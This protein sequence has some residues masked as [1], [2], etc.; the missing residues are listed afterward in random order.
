MFNKDNQSQ[1][2]GNNSKN[3]QIGTINN[4]GLTY[5]DARQIALDVFKANFIELSKEASDLAYE[6]ATKLI[7]GYFQ[8]VSKNPKI[9]QDE[10]KKPDIQSAIYEAQ[11]E[12]AKSGGEELR[13]LLTSL[14]VQ[15]TEENNRNLRQIALTESI[16]VV[17]KLTNEH[18]NILTLIFVIGRMEPSV[19]NKVE[20][21]D[22]FIND[23]IVPFI[24]P[25]KNDYFIY[26]HLIFAGCCSS[27]LGGGHWKRLGEAISNRYGGLLSKGFTKEEFEKELFPINQYPSLIINNLRDN[28]LLQI[29]ALSEGV[30]ET[31]AKKLKIT[32]DELSKLKLF[33]QKDIRDFKEIED[34][35]I[36][37]NPKMKDLINVWANHSIKSLDLTPI[38]AAIANA[39]FVKV[40][41]LRSFL[42]TWIK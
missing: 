40:T 8:E 7:D 30:L 23:F 6:R 1:K 39:N 36:S 10:F 34:Y 26:S 33:Y 13:V 20:H 11:K 4:Y 31:Q 18:I 37:V 17:G 9:S 15:R 41:G 19:I 12:Y 32:S 42:A 2:S 25:M 29:N 22:S 5:I 28:R 35:L 38:G 21:L 14:L 3:T 24:L 27:L 16:S